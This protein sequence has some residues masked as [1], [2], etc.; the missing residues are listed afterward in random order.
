MKSIA[1]RLAIWYAIAATATLAALCIAGYFALEKSLIHGLDLL[2]AS[3]FQQ[4]KA[5][6]GTDYPSLSRQAID[7]RIRSTT[8]YASVLFFIDVHEKNRGTIFQ[9]SNL[10]HAGIPDIPGEH[11]YNVDVA[12]VG[13]LRGAEFLLPPFDVMIGTPLKPVRDVMQ[14]YTQISVA[15][16]TIMLMISSAIGFVLSHLALRPVRSIQETASRINSD[17]L[18]ERIPEESVDDEVANLAAL[19]NQM[20]G[21]LE[22]SFNQIRRFTSEASHELKTPLSLIR[23]QAERLLAEGGLSA[24]QDEAV[25]AQLEEVARLNKIIEELLFISRAEAAAI[26]LARITDSPRTFLDNFLPDARVLCEH[27]G[28]HLLDAHNGAG[29]VTLDPK[30][31]RQVLLNL[32]VNAINVSPPNGLIALESELSGATWRISVEDQG[33]GVD[34]AQ[35]SRIFERFVRLAPEND[36]A[37]GGSGLGLAICRSIIELHKGRIW[38]E[39]AHSGSGLRVTFELPSYNDSAP[40]DAAITLR[41]HQQWHTD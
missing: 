22:S 23:L 8:D 14:G 37:A 24:A 5:R 10:H 26:P 21:R 17:N 41:R 3:E 9:S 12:N 19:L 15:L 32:I 28:I 30:W 36:A 31:I 35:Y 20:F 39:A 11:V 2:N 40:I 33:P 13:E 38:A 25:Q 34:A 4:L 1:S 27:R 16:V 6:L 29:T 7:E 18:G